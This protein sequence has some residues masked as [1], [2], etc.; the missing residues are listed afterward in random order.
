MA[1][2]FTKTLEHLGLVAG[3]CQEIKLAEIIDKALGDGGQRQVSFG[4]LFEAMI[5]NGLGFT[6]RTLHMFS[7]YFEDK[8][9]ERLLGPGI[10]AEHINDDALGRCLDALYEHGVSPLYQTI[11]EAVVRHLDLP[12]EAVHL[13]STSFHT[14]SQEKLSEGD[15]NP[16]QIT[17]GY[18]RDHRPE[19]NQV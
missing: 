19:L 1:Y 10:Q 5:L 12:C 16:V 18:S 7:E 15:F 2:P 8:P 6:G 11:G 3:F 9:L 4:K 14:D 13:D 17:K